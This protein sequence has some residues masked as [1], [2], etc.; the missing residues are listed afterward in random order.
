ILIL[1]MIGYGQRGMEQ[2]QPITGGEAPVGRF[3]SNAVYEGR[4]WRVTGSAPG[5]ASVS[6]LNETIQ[7][8]RTGCTSHP[9]VGLVS[10]SD[11]LQIK[12]TAANDAQRDGVGGPGLTA[13]N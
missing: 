12:R 1:R 4:R 10:E 6:S 2:V 8:R 5:D 3:E 9:A 11:S 7:I 13:I